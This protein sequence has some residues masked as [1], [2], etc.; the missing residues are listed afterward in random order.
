M[1][2]QQN[3]SRRNTMDIHIK[4]EVTADGKRIEG[5][6]DN[7]HYCTVDIRRAIRNGKNPIDALA[8]LAE[9]GSKALTQEPFRTSFAPGTRAELGE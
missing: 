7:D 1:V 2:L 9:V 8:Y 4:V 6:I 3:F 5:K